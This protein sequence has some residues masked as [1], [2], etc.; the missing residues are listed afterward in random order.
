MRAGG[1]GTA[2]ITVIDLDRAALIALYEATDGPNWVNSDNWLTDAPLWDWYGVRTD[3]SGRVVGLN[4][5]GKT[6][7]WPEV[8]PHGLEGPI[9]VELRFLEHLTHLLLSHNALT[10]PIPAELGSLERL[11]RL[12]LSHNGLT[13]PIPPELSNLTRMEKLQ[14]QFA[15]IAG[16]LCV[17]ANAGLVSWLGNFSQGPGSAGVQLPSVANA[18]PPRPAQGLPCGCSTRSRPT[19]S[20]ARSTATASAVA[21]KCCSGGSQ[22]GWVAPPL[23]STTRNRRC[24][25]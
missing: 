9:P 4:L 17:P 14:L 5:A 12:E 23:R 24:A 13:G 6:D 21:S 7:D 11:T 16:E 15:S 25:T 18:P 2:E 10:G 19:G 3:A 20:S 22:T 8:T 1:Q